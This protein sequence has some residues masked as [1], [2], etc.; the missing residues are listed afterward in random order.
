[1]TTNIL[2]WQ[3][4]FVEQVGLLADV[5]LPRSVARVL[6]WLVVCEPQ[7][8]SAEQLQ[9]TLRLS[10]GSVSAAAAT[11]VRAEIVT[12]VTFPGDRRIYYQLQAD[13]WQRLLR[14]RLHLLTHARRV[15]EQALSASGDGDHDRLVGMRDFYGRL[16]TQFARLLDEDAQP[17]SGKRPTTRR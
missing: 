14:T 12:R 3:E 9:A 4:V 17:K 7:H 8:Q 6:G 2:A 11:L 13:G 1:V 10:A 5:G 15:A 16:E